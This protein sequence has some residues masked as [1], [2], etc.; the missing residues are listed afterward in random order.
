[1]S[2]KIEVS[3]NSDL[4]KYELVVLTIIPDIQIKNDLNF[5]IFSIKNNNEQI[6]FDPLIPDSR[7]VFNLNTNFLNKNVY[8]IFSFKKEEFENIKEI[9]F[10][11]C[12][13]HI[14]WIIKDIVYLNQ[15]CVSQNNVTNDQSEVKH[16]EAS[17]VESAGHRHDDLHKAKA[18]KLDKTPTNNLKSPVNLKNIAKKRKK[19]S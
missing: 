1:M 6:I 15:Y 4:N 3:F 5:R 18:K 7:Y 2:T 19:V 16:I 8:F 9:N 11:L 14:S 13:E 10:G 17:L 12:H